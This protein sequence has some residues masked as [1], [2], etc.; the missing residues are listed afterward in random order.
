MKESPNS[1]LYGEIGDT[2]N[3]LNLELKILDSISQNLEYSFFYFTL[4]IYLL[5]IFT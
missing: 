3:L 1:I 2:A 5:S 4:T